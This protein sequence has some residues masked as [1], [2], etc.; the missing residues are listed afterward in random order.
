[1]EE[2]ILVNPQEKE[3]LINKL[4]SKKFEDFEIH[5]HFYN[6]DQR[7]RHGISLEQA[8]KIFEKFENIISVSKRKKI[9]GICLYFPI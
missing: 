1:M 7:P 8:K 6:R 4:K 2:D 9:K 3:I 5:S